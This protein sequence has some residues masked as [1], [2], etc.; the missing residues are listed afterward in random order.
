M[1]EEYLQKEVIIG[2]DNNLVYC[3]DSKGNKLSKETIINSWK[4]GYSERIVREKGDV[5][6]RSPQFG[7]LSA[8]RAHWVVSESPATVVM[9]TGTGKS[10]TMFSVIAS[11]RPATT[12]IIVPSN[13]LRKQLFENITHFGILGT[14]LGM[15]SESTIFPTCLLYKSSVK[16]EDKEKLV[17]ELDTVNVIVS[18]PTMIKKMPTDIFDKL[19]TN[20]ELVIFDEAHHLAAPDWRDVREKFLNKK[21]LQFTATPFRNDGKR[22]NGKIIFN[23][24]LGLAQ[25]SGYFQ[26]IDF[27]PIQEFDERNS[28]VKIA[29]IAVELLR[30]DLSDGY[31]HVLL[32][33]AKTKKRAEELFEKVYSQYG[34]LEPV[35]IHSGVKPVSLNRDSLQKVRSGKAKIVVCVDMFGEGID[36]PELKIAAIH[37]KYK[38]LP[39]TLQFIGRFARAKGEKI[40]N[41]KLITNVAN[42][43]LKEGIE[44]LYHQD[45]NWNELLHIKSDS[46]VGNEVEFEEFIEKFGKVHTDNIDLSQIRMKISTRMFKYNSSNFIKNGWKD[47]LNPERT[48]ILPNDEESVYIFIEEVE[49]PVPW[50]D[51]KDIVEYGYNFF[52][53]YHDKE[54][55]IIHINETDE[56]IGK[57]LI[58][59]MFPDA[60]QIVGDSVYRVLDGINR[61]MIGTIGLKQIPGGNISFRMFAGTDVKAGVTEAV[62]SSS[63]KSNLFGYG[64]KNGSKISIG[65]SYKGKIWM[66]WVEKINFWMQ[67]CREVGVKVLDDNINTADILKNS[68][69]LEEITEFPEGIPYK[70]IL[71]EK[72]ETSNTSTRVLYLPKEKVEYPFYESDLR[73]P[74][75]ESGVLIFEYWLNERKFIFEQHL[76]PTGFYYKQIAGEEIFVKKQTSSVKMANYFEEQPPEISFIQNNGTIV[77]V[78]ENLKVIVNPK[79]GIEL[80]EELLVPISWEEYGVDIKKE[81]Q[82][83]DRKVDSIQYATIHNIVESDSTIIFDDDGSGEIADIVSLRVDIMSRNLDIHFYHCKYSHG[84]NPGSRVSDLYEVC[85]QSEK[86]VMWNDNILELIRRLKFRENQRRKKYDDTR[87]E[88]GDIETL[89][90]IEKMV[91]SGFETN[92]AISIVQPGVSINKLT[93]EMTQLILATDSYLKDTYNLKLTCYFSE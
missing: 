54:N 35:L 39:I 48:T 83:R 59:K 41:A 62:A 85:G 60:R 81:S 47:V 84:N 92:L 86:S 66:R 29:E 69:V 34:D 32:A 64:F 52:V 21:I 63:T 20:V 57:R 93:S 6:L 24:S 75:I 80:S 53:I 51:Q 12:L 33:R 2:K 74:K 40:G 16:N 73:N 36:I 55:N 5:G 22:L 68:L 72:I 58:E 77:V 19:L 90:A 44:E 65:C 78:R 8:I 23:Y 49:L 30:K 14:E 82:G 37:D 61:L 91:K 45:S 13:L 56:G 9:P 31:N 18:T 89:S 88:K 76:T 87:I 10:E 17:Q 43:D 7:A 25:K 15:L 46:S 50:S 11:E 26:P 4:S 67:W 28:D 38:S 3:V 1:V 42:E 70:V 79:R 71:P 27:Y